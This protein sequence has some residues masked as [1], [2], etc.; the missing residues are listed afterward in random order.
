LGTVTVLPFPTALYKP[1]PLITLFAIIL[2][3]FCTVPIPAQEGTG[4]SLSAEQ[5][6]GEDIRTSSFM[7]LAT[8]CRSLG[9]SE[10][11][12]KEELA[13]R[14]RAYYNLSESTPER[15][16]DAK[17]I[18]IES[19]RT[20]EYFSLDV[21]DED[22]ARLRGG[23]TI[24]LRDGDTVHRISADEI[25]Y[26]RT[27]NVMTA[28]GGV[29]YIK[30][31]GDTIETFKGESITVDLDNWSSV[32]MDGLTEKSMSDSVSV[33][34][35][36]GT[37][38]SRSDEEVTIMNDAIIT[39]AKNPEA[40]WSLNASK[41]W[42]LPGADWAIFNAVLKVG[43]IPVLW[44][45]GFYFPADEVV[46]HPVIGYRSRWGN[47]VQTTTYIWGR[48]K[49]SE[50]SESSIS[51]IMGSGQNMERVRE[52]LFLRSTGK[53]TVDPNDKRLSLLFDAYA[54][55]G[56]YAGTELVLPKSKNGIFNGM[57]LSA[58]IGFT[59]NVYP[60]SYG[61]SPFL[62][63]D[64]SSEWN[65][66]RFFSEELPFRY[67]LDTKGALSFS[68]YGTL[69]WAFPFYSDAYTNN[70]FMD[71]SEVMDW[72]QMLKGNPEAST[73][74]SSTTI[75]EHSWRVNGTFT[76]QV[77]ALSPFVSSLSLSSISSFITFKPRNSLLLA[78]AVSPERTFFYPD[79]F[80]LYSISGTVAGTPLTLS[81]SSSATTN[82]DA[83]LKADPRM[84]TIRPPWELPA[85]ES[86]NAAASAQ[87][88]TDLS[89]PAL[90]QRFDLPKSG[91]PKFALDYEV[92]PTFVSETQFRSSPLNWP[93]REDIDWNELS[94][95]L[96]RAT[97]TGSIG[98]T[99]SQP[100]TSLYTSALRIAMSTTQEKY[101]YIN[102]E[103]EEFDTQAERDAANLRRYNASFAMLN[104][105][106]TSTLKPFYYNDIWGATTFQYALRGLLGKNV[107]NG[108]AT[109]PS[110]EWKTGEWT[111]EDLTANTLT[112]NLAASIRDKNQNLTLSA[113]LP[114]EDWNL[115]A[116]AIFRV[117]R[118]ETTLRG[119]LT[120]EKI[121]PFYITEM[122][123]FGPNDQIRFEQQ[124]TWD[125]ELEEYTSLATSFTWGNFAASFA[126]SRSRTY[127]FDPYI[128]WLLSSDEE[129]LNPRSL[130]FSYNQP[131]K[132]TELWNKRLSFS[133]GVNSSLN[134]DLQRY[135]YSSLNF[136][137]N[138]TLGIS[139]LFDIE[140][141]STSSNAVIY[142]YFHGLDLPLFPLD[143]G[144][145]PGETNFFIDL[146]NSFRFDNDTLRRN[147]GFKLKSFKLKLIHH[148]GDWDATLSMTLSPYL[149]KTGNSPVYKFNNEISFLVKWIPITEIK[150]ELAMNKDVWTMK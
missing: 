18:V 84:A 33:Y 127:D 108:T 88:G 122:I 117:W 131:L 40:Y 105:D 13:R 85:T 140:L 22:Y 139:K 125:P 94:S 63:Y 142:R 5:V 79:K 136:G 58:G 10:G 64:G 54:N 107:F 143:I 116:N 20:T 118:T 62:E 15:N 14:L 21:V 90:S 104:Y 111:K 43:E 141:S 97:A 55:L 46:F 75:G 133:I 135:T 48:P 57:D 3:F 39:N 56:F 130:R 100:E 31:S 91:G 146:F 25:L 24:S 4:S 47:F 134:F 27:R 8:W 65:K 2:L 102:E 19:A 113:I 11:G 29:E 129:K 74:V 1:T 70:D 66:S 147:S 42:L 86:K 6:Y 92:K 76:P 59:R 38:I 51:K 77:S 68:R 149:D 89:P 44:I 112:A 115:S 144:D 106:W 52:G 23:V 93:E 16:S 12:T 101:T 69:S 37:V 83:E 67:R 49:A 120:E 99:L 72:V 126:A 137:F 119:S 82:T 103:A 109:N 28:S 132:K 60:V 32:F 80:T 7:E 121:N 61:S 50:S 96:S 87:Q 124:I 123:K 138:F 41:L 114:P 53:K 150:S 110:W 148:L 35:F 145:V 17:L 9:L 95:T 26:N 30:E 98:F 36:T 45:P 71:R 128:G 34:Q 81:R 78:N 73:T